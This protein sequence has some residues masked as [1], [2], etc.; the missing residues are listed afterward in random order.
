MT[1]AKPRM[2][3]IAGRSE[4]ICR[5]RVRAASAAPRTCQ[6]KTS[7][8]IRLWCL[9]PA[10]PIGDEPHLAA[11]LKTRASLTLPYTTDSPSVHLVLPR[12]IERS[13]R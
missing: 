11:A 5:D 6:A 10:V 2:E 13:E 7:R 1:L 4:Q 3:A 8:G 12:I 9:L